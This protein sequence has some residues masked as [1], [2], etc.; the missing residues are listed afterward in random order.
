MPCFYNCFNSNIQPIFSSIILINKLMSLV[1]IFA[2]NFLCGLVLIFCNDNVSNWQVIS[3][4]HFI[5]AANYMSYI[6][7]LDFT[8]VVFVVV[9]RLFFIFQFSSIYQT[10][11]T[12]FLLMDGACISFKM[13][14]NVF[15][16]TLLI[17]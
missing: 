4:W 10:F 7:Y 8:E 13:R 2:I 12:D 15:V 17:N 6:F 14:E 5:A 9:C 16:V 3:W 11:F 1:F